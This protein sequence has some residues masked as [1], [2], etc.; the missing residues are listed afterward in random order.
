ME[1]NVDTGMVIVGGGLAGLSAACYLARAGA[2]VTLLEKASQLGGRA[3]TQRHAGFSFN[4][5]A[6]ALY[7][8]G[9]ASRVLTELGVV[10]SG[11][12]P[13]PIF[14]LH[15]GVLSPFPGDPF[16]LLR[17]RLLNA[18]DKLAL[19]TLFAKLLRIDP[20]SQ[21]NL[22]VHE[23][24]ECECGRPRVRSLLTAFARTFSFSTALD[25]VSA[26]V[27]LT[28]AQLGLRHPIY[29]LNGGW[30]TLA[31][32]LSR[33][34]QQ[35]GTR[36][37]T[38]NVVSV[39]EQRDGRVHG[40]LLRD[41]GRIEASAVLLATKPS[42]ASRLAETAGAH[43]LRA[44]IAQFTPAQ[45][46]CLDVAL[47]RLPNPQ[48]PVVKDLDRPRFLAAQSSYARVA[49]AGAALIHTFKQLDPR[50]PGDAHA[51]EC[52]LEELLDA[53]QHGWR[54]LLIRRVFLP[55][56]EASGVLPSAAERGFC[57]R[58]QVR[59]TEL[60]GL[61]LA[62]DWVGP[63][64]YQLDASL[65]SARQAAQLILREA[66]LP[67]V[68]ESVVQKASADSPQPLALVSAGG[69]RGAFDA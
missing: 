49:P 19:M 63:E 33:Q 5:G 37:I 56:I 57:G 24:L 48:H 14:A 36:I 21:A 17:S 65:A 61:Y 60:G 59:V 45:L 26:E 52:E 10:Y 23:W 42:E 30:Q 41:G 29:Y 53:V 9:A 44:R 35:L 39:I 58:P 68:H 13:Q 38:G 1:R 2:R 62:G 18:A 28:R 46:A 16:A 27:F 50:A 54:A 67:L 12:R 8:G 25:F 3:S 40:V 6:H 66:P 4:L 15:Q 31:D 47:R 64:G 51:D 22:S 32:A 55:R 7:T 20:S 69:S 34:A 43:M 11:R